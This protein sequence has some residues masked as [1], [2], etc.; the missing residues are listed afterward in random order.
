MMMLYKNTKTKFR[1][2]DGDIYFFDVVTGVLLEDTFVQYL[3][4]VRVYISSIDNL[5]KSCNSS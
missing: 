2:P 4:S 1:S 3:C 5:S